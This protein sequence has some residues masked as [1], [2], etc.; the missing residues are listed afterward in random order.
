MTTREQ[1]IEIDTITVANKLN[2]AYR[3]DHPAFEDDTRS[4]TMQEK[5]K[6]HPDLRDAIN[7]ATQAYANAIG[8]E[9]DGDNGWLAFKP[10]K[11]YISGLTVKVDLEVVIF[12]AE[13]IKVSD[14]PHMD[15]LGDVVAKLK[16][17]ALQYITGKKR[18]NGEK[19]EQQD[20]F[21]GQAPEEY[22]EE[23]LEAEATEDEQRSEEEG[24]L[25]G[26]GQLAGEREPALA[27]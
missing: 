11:F 5:E 4:W 3:E 17:E 18:T 22:S 26:A 16:G 8:F 25:E 27:N 23:D 1:H 10:K 6:P 24:M 7:A 12:N 2:F 19:Y 13:T 21:V 15:G 9:T 14:G 20:L